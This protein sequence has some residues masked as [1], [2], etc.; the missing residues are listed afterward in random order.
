MR[1]LASFTQAAPR[2]DDLPEVVIVAD[3]SFSLDNASSEQ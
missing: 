1:I 3:E 2:A